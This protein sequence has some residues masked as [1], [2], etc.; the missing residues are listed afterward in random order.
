VFI[1]LQTVSVVEVPDA[2]TAISAA[3]NQSAKHIKPC[4]TR[5]IH[6]T[7][8]VETSHKN[9]TLD[10]G[11]MVS[12]FTW[13]LLLYWSK[14]VKRLQVSIAFIDKPQSYVALLAIWDHTMLPAT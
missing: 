4:Q 10:L 9:Q 5:S 6:R 2:H 3:S 13:I 8:T 1:G 12:V 7:I 11:S 14:K